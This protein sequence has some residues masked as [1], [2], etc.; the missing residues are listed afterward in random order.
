MR[1][2]N[3]DLVRLLAAVQ[4]VLYHGMEHLKPS[5]ILGHWIAVFPKC[6]PGVPIFFVISGF[7]ISASFEKSE[8]IIRYG[9]NRVLRIYPGLWVCFLF[10]ALSVL[11]FKPEVFS[12]VSFAGLAGWIASQLTFCQFYNPEF[13]RPYGIGALNGSLWTI[14]VELQFYALVPLVYFFFASK[15]KVLRLNWVVGLMLISLA[16]NQL[17]SLGLTAYRGAMWHNLFTVSFVPHFWLFL[18][19]VILQQKFETIRPY[20]EGKFLH[21]ALIHALIVLVA[22]A[23]GMPFGS[24]YP[25]PPVSLSLAGLTLAAA[26]TLP[27]LSGSLLNQ[28]DISYGLY[29]YH[30]LVINAFVHMGWTGNLLC[31]AC[32]FAISF[33]LAFL[34][35][36]CIERP[37]IRLKKQLGKRKVLV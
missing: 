10:G 13:L 22:I 24:N 27:E 32:M 35:W 17:Q 28:N 18:L 29:I 16:L 7:L 31:L 14:P 25:F 19:G 21:W 36:R 26:Y 3:F 30:V 12:G 23:M 5:E 9:V 34:S 1:P 6:L 8:S 2:N 33:L 15:E 11:A 4:V 20:V 37:A